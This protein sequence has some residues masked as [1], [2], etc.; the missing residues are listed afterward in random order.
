MEIVIRETLRK[1]S[2]GAG[3][4]RAANPIGVVMAQGRPGIMDSHCPGVVLTG[5]P[6]RWASTATFCFL[7]F[8]PRRHEQKA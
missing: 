5:K 4:V 3:C 1:P 2:L 7:T 8:H 6:S